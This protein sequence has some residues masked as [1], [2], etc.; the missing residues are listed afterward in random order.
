MSRGKKRRT[1][2]LPFQFTVVDELMASPTDPT[3]AR[4]I[5]PHLARV[6]S[7]LDALMRAEVPSLDAWRDLSDAVNILS[8]M[9]ELGIVQDESDECTKAKNAMGEAGA[10]HLEMGT[11]RLSGSGARTLL[12]L[13]ADYEELVRMM[14]ERDLIR[15]IR[16]AE[17]R[18]RE[19]LQG[20][21]AAGD[22]VFAL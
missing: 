11:L 16:R 20:K 8:A 22:K 14:P 7:G 3:P 1:S 5:D 12:D 4:R 21:V 2:Q 6:R 18:V 10:R 19:I 17:R 9:A 13:L 15:S